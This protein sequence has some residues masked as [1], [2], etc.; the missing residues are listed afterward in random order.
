MKKRGLVAAPVIALA[1]IAAA[2][3]D[4]K[5]SSSSTT[6]AAGGGGSTTTAAAGCKISTPVKIIGLAEKPPE[7]PNAIPDTANGWE[8]GVADINAAGGICGQPLSFER[9]ALSPTDTAAAK[10]SFLTA[11]DKKPTAIVGIPSS[12]PVVALAPE[13]AKAGI[14]TIYFSAAPSVFVG[15]PNSVGS[16]WGF[17]I[18]PRNAASAQIQVDYL[19]KDK[20]FKKIGLL[21]INNSFGTTS[22]DVATKQIAANGGTVAGKEVHEAADTNLTAKVLALKNSGAEAIQIFSFPNNQANFYNQAAD[23]GLTVPTMGG[24]SAALA[25]ATGI[26][27]PAAL[28]T[29]YGI[30][31]C[32]PAA[33]T[34]GTPKKF[35]DAYKAKYNQTAGYSAALAYDSLGIIAAAVKSANSTDP[36]AVA[37]ALRKITYAGACEPGY[38]ADSGQGLHHL[39]FIESFSSAGPKIEK[40]VDVP[41]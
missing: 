41:G 10:T 35:A 3:G 30:D 17:I 7:G 2:C 31:D 12:G 38:K 1:L 37:D 26:V 15:A 32:V 40:K 8:L 22:C 16:E 27:K 19:M 28:P 21:C 34:T 25:L 14:P 6:T 4:S 5:S 23:N 20:G 11:V 39:S 18:R 24:A 9:L 36:K 13:V 33:E 29:I